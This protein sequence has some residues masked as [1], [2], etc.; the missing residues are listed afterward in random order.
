M[1]FS[2]LQRNISENLEILTEWNYL[3]L[4]VSFPL[5]LLITAG[6]TI[7]LTVFLKKSFLIKK[8]TYLLVNL[9]IVDLLVGV[10]AVERSLAVFLPF[11]HRLFKSSHYLIAIAVV[12]LLTVCGLV[13]IIIMVSN[14]FNTA[15][16]HHLPW[17][18]TLSTPVLS[19]ATMLASYL[20]IWIKLK[21]FTKFRR[22]R[23]IQENSKL[24]KTLFIVTLVSLGTWMPK[25]IQDNIYLHNIYDNPDVIL[26]AIL[27]SLL[28]I[29]SLLN[30]IVYSFRMPEF[31]KELRN[32]FC[33]CK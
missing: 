16:S 11:H 28:L 12:W 6:N 33:K 19:L 31:R 27:T 13:T 17:L 8:S 10:S 32:M 3:W 7:A 9:T 5:T 22:C 23:T 2:G 25:T 26:Y 29:N 21:F 24:T 14:F 4:R 1:S 30:V 15:K 20:S 18:F